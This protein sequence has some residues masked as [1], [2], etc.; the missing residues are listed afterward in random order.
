MLSRRPSSGGSC[1]GDARRFLL[2]SLAVGEAESA[3]DLDLVADRVTDPVLARR[4]YRHYAE[5]LRHARAFRRHLEAEGWACTPL[6]PEL[7]YDRLAQRFG[8]GTP[9][10]RLDD[11]RPFDDD[12][13]ILFF[14]G[15]KAGEER[16]CQEMEGLIGDL[17]ADQPTA[18]AAAGDPRDELRHVAYATEALRTL[19]ARC[20][21]RASSGALERS[22]RRARAPDREPRVHGAAAR[23]AR[24]PAGDPRDR[25]PRDRRRRC[26]AGSSGRPRRAHRRPD[27][28]A[29]APTEPRA[30]RAAVKT[31]F[32]SPPSFDGFDGGA[33]SRYQAR[34]EIRSF[35][36]PTWLAQAAALVPGRVLIVAPP[37]GLTREDVVARAAGFELIV[38]HT[39]TP[40]TAGDAEAAAALKAP[41]ARADR[42][43]AHPLPA[44]ASPA[45]RPRTS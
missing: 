45:R 28:R 8:M 39:S 38:R 36:Y 42:V 1:A 35:W 33:G 25:R 44:R 20:G 17:A 27:A 15:S 40:S 37:A 26:G 31:L 34:R 22:A 4:I 19:A 23:H 9:R 6:P 29:G 13:L 16:A 7:D 3:Q 21:R 5:E 12:D 30:P 32:L 18:E 10:A 2:N 11:P 41:T 14:S 43:R 24:R